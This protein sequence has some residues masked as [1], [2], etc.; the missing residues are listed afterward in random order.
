M[1]DDAD[2]I[3]KTAKLVSQLKQA[4]RIELLPYHRYGISMYNVL[5]RNYTLQKVGVPS[6]EHLKDLENIIRS[7][8]VPTQIGG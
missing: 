2:N 4:E 1:N 8:H 6:E 7:Y 5:C 3:R